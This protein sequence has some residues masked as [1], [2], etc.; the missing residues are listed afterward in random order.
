MRFRRRRKVTLKS[1]I[2]YKDVDLLRGFMDDRGKILPRRLT[3]LNTKQ[4]RQ[5]TKAIKRARSIALLPFTR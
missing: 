5:V 2:D 4:Q 1:R 3:R